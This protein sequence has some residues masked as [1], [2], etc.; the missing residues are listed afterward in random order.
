MALVTVRP[1][2]PES[3]IPIGSELDIDEIDYTTIS[4]LR[5]CNSHKKLQKLASISLKL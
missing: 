4:R 2:M 1:P 5:V 3:N